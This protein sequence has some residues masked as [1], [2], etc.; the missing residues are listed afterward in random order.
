MQPNLPE[1]LPV[2]ITSRLAAFIDSASFERLDECAVLTAKLCV[3]DSI[4]V[5][6]AGCHEDSVARLV[7]VMM[8]AG[9]SGC[10]TLIGHRGGLAPLDAALVNG[11]AMHALDF[12]DVH[13][14]MYGHPSAPI[15]AALLAASDLFERPGKTMLAALTVGVDVACTLGRLVG[16][17]HYAVGFHATGTLGSIG[18]AAACAKFIGC[19]L[20]QTQHALALAATQAAGL[21]SMFGSMA[22]PLHAGKAAQVGL[23]SSLLAREGFLASP[24][25]LE[26]AQ[27]FLETHTSA[28]SALRFDQAFDEMPFI[29]TVEFKRYAACALTHPAIRACESLGAK[30]GHEPQSLAELEVVVDPGHATVCDIRVPI[31]GNKLKFSIRWLCA[32]AWTG[33]DLQA[34]ESYSNAAIKDEELAKLASKVVVNFEP[35]PDKW[36]VRATL[37][38][39]SVESR[40]LL[41][42]GTA[43]SDASETVHS[44][45][46]ALLEPLIDDAQ[47][48]RAF[49]SILSIDKTKLF[50]AGTI[51]PKTKAP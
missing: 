15:V 7:R 26:G 1:A 48:D 19:S 39:G 28:P 9:S 3:A 4:A 29:K 13:P 6:V 24:Q 27:G 37:V 46:F 31:D 10:S 12:D 38:D 40:H 5:A 23:L 30:T 11:T 25:G 33:W 42:F 47:V 45:F 32:M 16:P 22:K 18:A 51:V 20:S 17:A 44:K 50:R 21:K 2:A 35:E 43:R 36:A 14:A 49:E 41:D 8:A 34:L